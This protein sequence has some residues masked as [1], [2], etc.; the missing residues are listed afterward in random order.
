MFHFIILLYTDTINS[1]NRRIRRN[2]TSLTVK[3]HHAITLKSDEDIVKSIITESPRSELQWSLNG[4]FIEI[5]PDRLE[6]KDFN[7]GK[8]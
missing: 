5:E 3:E 4:I 1:I 6:L 8:N 7:I 2:Y